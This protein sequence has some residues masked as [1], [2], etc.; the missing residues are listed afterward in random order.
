MHYELSSHADFSVTVCS[1]QSASRSVANIQ[2]IAAD[3]T[4]A[5]LVIA[6]GFAMLFHSY[7]ISLYG[8]FTISVGL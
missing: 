2:C 4:T 8:H 1:L 5:C 7:I 6:D 3:A